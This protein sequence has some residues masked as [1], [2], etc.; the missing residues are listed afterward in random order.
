MSSNTPSLPAVPN[1]LARTSTDQDGNTPLHAAARN[2][3]EEI[4]KLLIDAGSLVD[5]PNRYKETPLHWACYSDHPG[6]ASIINQLLAAGAPV[7]VTA[8]NGWSPLPKAAYWG[9]ARVVRQLLEIGR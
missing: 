8:K 9:H 2:G 7:G 4:V 5:A 1:A 3:H 6:T